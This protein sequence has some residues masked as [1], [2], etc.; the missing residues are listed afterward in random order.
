MDKNQGHFEV[1]NK[2][3]SITFFLIAYCHLKSLNVC[4]KGNNYYVEAMRDQNCE[5]MKFWQ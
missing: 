3:L 5:E 1:W 2:A 4:Q